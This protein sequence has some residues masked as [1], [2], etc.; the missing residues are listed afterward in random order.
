MS[1]RCFPWLFVAIIGSASTGCAI[2]KDLFGDNDTG[3]DI[4]TDDTDSDS[5]ADTDSDT[6]TDTEPDTDADADADSDS[7]A[8]ADADADSDADADADSDADS[9]LVDCDEQ[10]GP[11]PTIDECVTDYI[12]CGDTVVST[13][14]GGTSVMD[15]E[16]YEAWYCGFG[17]DGDYTGT[18]RIYYFENEGRVATIELD[19]PCGD[20]DLIVAKWEQWGQD[21]SCPTE[22]TSN[23]S[24]CD[25]D[26]SSGGGEV[27]VYDTNGTEYSYLII[28]DGKEPTEENFALSVTCE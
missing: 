8:D 2:F 25:M 26:E 24:V 1:Q 27:V 15:E 10:L 9:D 22:S 5:D 6:D 14:K 18:E 20:L 12:D 28:V 4:D 16:E 21:G 11:A 23:L 3:D 13:I 7:D 17:F 19:S